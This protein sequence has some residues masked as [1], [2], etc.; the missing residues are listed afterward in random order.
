MTSLRLALVA[1]F[2]GLFGGVAV[3]QSTGAED[4]VRKM[5]VEV[6]A[7]VRKDPDIATSPAKASAL[8]EQRLLPRF[9]F[10]RITQVAMGRNW[11]KA[12]PAEQ[13]QIVSEF[14][15]LLVRTY[16]NAIGTL[17]ELEVQV[18]DSRSNGPSDVTVRTLMVGRAKPVSI[19]YTLTSAGGGWKV[20]DVTVE[21]ISLVSAYRDEFTGLVSS[22]GVS[23]LIAALQKKNTK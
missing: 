18:K 8:I 9:D 3:A 4:L 20:Y 6:T 23:G 22:S 15:H 16:S 7:A 17:K 11:A 2:F 1:A 14:T 12:T 13:H 10:Q 19:D 21:N 5:A